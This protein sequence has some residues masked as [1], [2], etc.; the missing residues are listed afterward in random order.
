[1]HRPRIKLQAE[2]AEVAARW[3]QSGFPT[4]V[5]CNIQG[6]TAATLNDADELILHTCL[7][8]LSSAEAREQVRL[9]DAASQ[10]DISVIVQS[11]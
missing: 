1:M 2:E 7:E 6:L 11:G 8:E 3:A 9:F 5:Y 4:G 10:A